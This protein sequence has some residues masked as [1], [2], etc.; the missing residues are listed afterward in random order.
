MRACHECVGIKRSIAL[1][2]IKSSKHDE[3]KKRLL[4]KEATKVDIAVVMKQH[5]ADTHC[6]EETLPGEL[7]VNRVRVMKA[8]L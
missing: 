8:F 2:H 5:D 4:Q 1:N 6:K 7:H 3:G